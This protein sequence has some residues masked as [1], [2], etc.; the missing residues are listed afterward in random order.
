ML[1][2]FQWNSYI[3]IIEDNSYKKNVNMSGHK[4][5]YT[6]DPVNFTAGNL[7]KENQ[8]R[9]RKSSSRKLAK[10]PARSP[11]ATAPHRLITQEHQDPSGSFCWNLLWQVQVRLWFWGSLFCPLLFCR[12]NVDRREGGRGK[13]HS[14]GF[15]TLRNSQIAFLEKIHFLKSLFQVLSNLFCWRKPIIFKTNNQ[16]KRG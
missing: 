3:L 7:Y 10:P 1:E 11:S 13:A 2:S 6:L 12:W 15:L 5:V 4:N 8:K 16:K 14:L 9:K